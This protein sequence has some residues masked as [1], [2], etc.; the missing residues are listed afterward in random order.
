MICS[1]FHVVLFMQLAETKAMLDGK[2]SKVQDQLEGDAKKAAATQAKQLKQR[3][4]EL[5]QLEHMHAT[6]KAQLEERIS[7]LEGKLSKAKASAKQSELR[8]AREAEGFTSDVSLLRQQ[9]VA[10]DRRFAS[11]AA[12]EQTA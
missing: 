10:V 5:S 9:L 7:D 11:D 3:E 4:L 1:G 6:V 2:L 8:R 12:A